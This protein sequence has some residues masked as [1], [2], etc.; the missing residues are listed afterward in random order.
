MRQA[1]ATPMQGF[2][3]GSDCHSRKDRERQLSFFPPHLLVYSNMHRVLSFFFPWAKS[4]VLEFYFISE[5]MQE[6][7]IGFLDREDLLENG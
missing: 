6:T 4:F 5:F 3:T 1:T 7:P 2:V